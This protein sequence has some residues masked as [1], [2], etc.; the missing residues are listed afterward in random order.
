MNAMLQDLLQPERN[1][2]N[3]RRNGRVDI[4]TGTLEKAL[5]S[6]GGCSTAKKEII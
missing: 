3:Q 5:G 2:R 1:T 4:I 6:I